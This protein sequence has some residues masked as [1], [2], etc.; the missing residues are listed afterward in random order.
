MRAP[1]VETTFTPDLAAALGQA[2][3]D[4]PLGA[5]PS[6][7]D[8]ARAALLLL[9]DEPSTAPAIAALLDGPT[10]ERFDIGLPRPSAL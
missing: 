7:G 8:I 5:P 10:P 2:S 6:D 1:G 9:A 3:G 4:A